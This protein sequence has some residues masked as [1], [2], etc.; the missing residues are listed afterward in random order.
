MEIPYI[1]VWSVSKSWIPIIRVSYLWLSG[2]VEAAS[3][4]VWLSV[5][6]IYHLDKWMHIVLVV[7]SDGSLSRLAWGAVDVNQ[8]PKKEQMQWIE[9]IRWIGCW[10]S[11]KLELRK[12]QISWITKIWIRSWHTKY[13]VIKGIKIEIFYWWFLLKLSIYFSV[14]RNFSAKIS[15]WPFLTLLFAFSFTLR[16]TWSGQWFLLTKFNKKQT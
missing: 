11:F 3:G 9:W 2:Q 8:P 15:F 4:G 5:W 7:L 6:H 13:N 16:A 14:N 10:S 1:F 12:G